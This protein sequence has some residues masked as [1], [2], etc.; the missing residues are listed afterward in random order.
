MHF[1]NL[2]SDSRWIKKW[3]LSIPRLDMVWQQEETSSL[4]FTYYEVLDP[5][6]KSTYTL[7]GKNL[8]FN[9]C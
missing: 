8:H 1:D 9:T 2:I 7:N 5:N 3:L 4:S 6:S